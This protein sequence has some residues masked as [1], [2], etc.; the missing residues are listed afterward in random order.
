MFSFDLSSKSGILIFTLYNYRKGEGMHLAYSGWHEPNRLNSYAVFNT[1]TKELKILHYDCIKAPIYDKSLLIYT[2][3]PGELAI[4]LKGNS[5]YYFDH[6]GYEVR[7]AGD[8]LFFNK[9]TIPG[10]NINISIDESSLDNP[11]N[12]PD[13]ESDFYIENNKI[14]YNNGA[15]YISDYILKEKFNNIITCYREVDTKNGH[16]KHLMGICDCYGNLLSEI[17]YDEIWVSS[18]QI[19]RNKYIRVKINGQFGLISFEGKEIL[20][21]IFDFVDDYEGNI[22]IVNHG[23]KLIAAGDLSVLYE[24]DGRILENV[25]GWMT[26]VKGYCPIIHIGLLDSTG[27]LYKF[28][29]KR[30]LWGKMEMYEDLGAAFHDGLLPVFSP[31]RG[32]G[33]V[34][35]DSNEIIECKYCEIS[36]FENGKAKVRLDCEYG[37]I[38]TKDAC[39]LIRRARK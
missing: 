33:Y 37:Y 22:A 32:Y 35:I 16:T 23:K 28:Y 10:S 15:V 30:G 34:D 39:L 38:N 9:Y 27:K 3:R 18:N 5:C 20:P 36:D 25:D 12:N 19:I 24:T 31:K 1:E 26:V 17:K 2:L 4:G 7:Y 13:K 6:N 11:K 8:R 29:N 14:V 21:V